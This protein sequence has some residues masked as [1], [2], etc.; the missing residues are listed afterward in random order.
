MCCDA[1]GHL[2]LVCDLTKHSFLFSRS[3]HSEIIVDGSHD[4]GISTLG[5]PAFYHGSAPVTLQDEQTA[6]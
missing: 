2:L 1:S 4:D 3:F 5:D 6:R